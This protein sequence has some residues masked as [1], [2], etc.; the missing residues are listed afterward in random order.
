MALVN[1]EVRDV[2]LVSP[3]SVANRVRNVPISPDQGNQRP[4]TPRA[5]TT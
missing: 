4:A 3:V 5:I 2:V 1:A